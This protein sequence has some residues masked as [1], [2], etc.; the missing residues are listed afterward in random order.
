MT[1]NKNE[2]W[3]DA[4]K[5]APETSDVIIVRDDKGNEDVSRYVNGEFYLYDSILTNISF[6]RPKYTKL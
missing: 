3:L 2:G 6:W 5:F 4:D 1:P